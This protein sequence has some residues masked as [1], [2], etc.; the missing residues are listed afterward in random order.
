MNGRHNRRLQRRVQEAHLRLL[1]LPGD[2]DWQTQRERSLFQ[3]TWIGGLIT[4]CCSPVL[5]GWARPISCE[6]YKL[7]AVYRAISTDTYYI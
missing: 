2:V 7:S 5:L 3:G 4:R 1:A 6:K